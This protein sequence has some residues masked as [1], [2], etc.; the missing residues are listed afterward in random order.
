MDGFVKDMPSTAK[1]YGMAYYTGNVIPYYWDY[2]SYFTFNYNFFSSS[3][4]YSLP[5]HL[6]AV[7]APE[8]VHM[9]PRVLL[10]AKPPTI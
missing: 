3:M 1:N 7:A 9:R 4:S 10:F 6:F 8:L 5:N 2:A